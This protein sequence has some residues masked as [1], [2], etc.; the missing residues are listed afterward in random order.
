MEE[1][2]ALQNEIIYRDWWRFHYTS[3]YFKDALIFDDDM[4]EEVDLCFKWFTETF[5]KFKAPRLYPIGQEYAYLHD[6][7]EFSNCL[8]YAYHK[9]TQSDGF[10]DI[11]YEIL[12]YE[13]NFP[14][15][16]IPS[17]ELV[18]VECLHELT[19]EFGYLALLL[20]GR[21]DYTSSWELFI[22]K[23]SDFDPIRGFMQTYSYPKMD[24]HPRG[25]RI[26]TVHNCQEDNEDSDMVIYYHE[27]NTFSHLKEEVEAR[28]E[29]GGNR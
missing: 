4:A 3:R 22:E 11:R 24:D 2:A 12:L 9:K 7:F 15:G 29:E 10:V 6:F 17:E 19:L 25:I 26:S 21:P 28:W 16:R 1:L 27:S 18:Y 23:K 5:D 13:Y 14:L 8:V 20:D